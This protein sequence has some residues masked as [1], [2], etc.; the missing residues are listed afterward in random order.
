M[1]NFRLSIEYP[2]TVRF[3]LHH[4]FREISAEHASSDFNSCFSSFFA[5]AYHSIA[6]THNNN[7]QLKVRSENRFFFTLD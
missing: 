7:Y 4:L 5:Q 1:F 6:N 2:K 3:E